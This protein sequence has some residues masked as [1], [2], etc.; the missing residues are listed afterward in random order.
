METMLCDTE[1]NCPPG[2][3]VGEPHMGLVGGDW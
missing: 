2:A 3:E 1:H